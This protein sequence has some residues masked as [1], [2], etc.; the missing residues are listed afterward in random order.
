MDRILS[1][2]STTERLDYR[3]GSESLHEKFKDDRERGRYIFGGLE[4]CDYTKGLVERLG[5][6]Y[7]AFKKLRNLKKD[8]QFY[9]ITEPSRS[10]NPDYQNLRKVLGEE[11]L[12]IKS[13]LPER[14]C[15]N[16]P[17]S[18]LRYLSIDQN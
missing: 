6:F 9:Q 11:V 13:K 18:T 14:F 1:E 5:I 12:K 3:L 10:D 15:Y 4:R 7:N 17:K 2:V 8:A 16:K